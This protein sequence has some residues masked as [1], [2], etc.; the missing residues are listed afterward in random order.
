M[1]LF[2]F[3]LVLLHG[4]L[5]FDDPVSQASWTLTSL[6]SLMSSFSN[7]ISSKGWND[8]EL[9]D[10]STDPDSPY[11]SSNCSRHLLCCPPQRPQELDVQFIFSR[12]KDSS[13]L[14]K[15]H[16]E[17]FKDKIP[18]DRSIAWIIH[19]FM[20]DIHL[21]NVFNRTK[22]AYIDR[23]VSVIIVDWTKGNREY[24]QSIAN[25]RV[26]GALVGQMMDWLNVH[27]RS[28]CV[29]F[30]LGSHIC[31]EAGSFLKS[32]GK[33]LRECHGVDPAGPA[34]DGCNDFR[35]SLDPSDCGL[36]TSIHATQYT[37]P[38][39]ILTEH[40]WGTSVKTG[41]CDFWIKHDAIDKSSCNILG[42]VG[43][44]TVSLFK[45]DIEKFRE[46][47]MQI[48]SCRHLIGME[49]Y[50]RHVSGMI[51]LEGVLVKDIENEDESL[52]ETMFA[53][54]DDSCS[55]SMN[56]DYKITI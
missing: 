34:F 14:I 16:D 37:N 35:I 28:L 32:R 6:K 56:V 8:P 13:T 30:S 51:N 23:G 48:G 24:F 46:N 44:A 19:G 22:D 11:C 29:G 42:F 15:V 52:P 53:P 36:V 3:G 41:D 43:N 47:V 10:F 5:A 49:L 50:M 20:N 4:V 54:P 40:R 2:V 55:P 7:C 25:V 33:V 31:G 26:V 45:G 27:D 39:A 21:D 1:F 18:D 9:G 12:D 17:D 38:I